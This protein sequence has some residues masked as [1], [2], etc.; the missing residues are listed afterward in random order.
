MPQAAAQFWS[1]PTGAE[2]LGA[3]AG[4]LQHATAAGQRE[5]HEVIELAAQQWSERAAVVGPGGALSFEQLRARVAI[6][7]RRSARAAPPRTAVAVVL[8][9]GP[10]AVAACLACMV[11]GR[12]CLILNADHPLERNTAILRTASPALAIVADRSVAAAGIIPSGLA[13]LT[14]DE[15]DELAP[16]A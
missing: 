3:A 7:A 6:L 8:P 4:L 12:I 15:V 1:C 5:A 16:P 11:A 13:W 9:N 2:W 10:A 14:Y